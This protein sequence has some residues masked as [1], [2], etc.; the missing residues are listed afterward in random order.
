MLLMKHN[1]LE[2]HQNSYWDPIKIFISY[3]CEYEVEFI[4]MK[5]LVLDK[6]PYRQT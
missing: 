1:T 2:L 3:D 6:D 4:M 5:Y